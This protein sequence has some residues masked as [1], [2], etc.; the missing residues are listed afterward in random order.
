MAGRKPKNAPM[1]QAEMIEYS[2]HKRSTRIYKEQSDEVK[3]ESISKTVQGALVGLRQAESKPRIDINDLAAV[4][5]IVEVY[6]ET[7]VMNSYNP[8]MADIAMILGYTRM[9]LYN[10]MAKHDTE[11][12]KF[13]HQ[14]HDKLADILAE[15]ALKG[16]VNN[17]TAIFLLKALYGY[18]D[19]TS[20]EILPNGAGGG[21]LSLDEIAMRAGLLSDKDH[22]NND[23]DYKAKYRRMIGMEE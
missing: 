5:G 3:N 12:A 19:T 11:T 4:R 7:C 16:N 14:V 17:I 13:L 8:T 1:S 6:L 23:T 9:G 2:K 20:L 21:E 18:R 10:Y 22:P 15:N